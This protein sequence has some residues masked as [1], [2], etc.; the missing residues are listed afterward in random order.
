MNIK[1]TDQKLRNLR[2]FM[3]LVFLLTINVSFAQTLIIGSGTTRTVNGSAAGTDSGPMLRVSNTSTL[4]FSKYHYLYTQAELS[5]IPAGATITGI[6]WHKA[7]DAV[8]NS[9]ADFAIWLRN[10]SRTSILP[11]T[12][13][14]SDLIFNATKVYEDTTRLTTDTGWVNFNITPF[15]Y[16]GYALEISTDFGQPTGVSPFSSAGLAWSRDNINDR[17]ISQNAT[18]LGTSLTLARTVRPMIRFTYTV[19]QACVGTPN[20]GQTVSSDTFACTNNAI[21]LDLRGNTLAPGVTFEWEYSTNNT[22]YTS[23]GNP[24]ALPRKNVT[25][26]ADTWVRC[27]VVCNGG[28]AVYSNPLLIKVFNA[29]NGTYTVNAA[30]PTGGTNFK[31][32]KDLVNVLSCAGLA[33]STI[34]NIIPNSGPYYDKLELSNISGLSSVNTLRILGNNNEIIVNTQAVNG[35]REIALLSNVNNVTLKDIK[36]KSSST[37]A[38]GMLI[39]NGCSADS[40]VNCTIDLSNIVTTSSLSNAGIIFSGTNA[41]VSA[42]GSSGVGCVVMGNTII[43]SPNAGGVYYGIGLSADADSNIIYNNTIQNAYYAGIYVNINEHNKI[44]NNTIT[45]SNKMDGY[46]TYYG[47]YTVSGNT[48]GNVIDGNK[49]LM[50]VGNG[51]SNTSA[52][53]GIYALGDGTVQNPVI[54][55]NNLIMGFDAGASYGLYASGTMHTK[56]YHNTIN[57]DKVTNKNYISYGIYLTGTN[58]GLDIKNNIVNITG[59]GL[60][61]KFGVYFSATSTTVGD[62]QKNNIYLNSSVT[63]GNQYYGYYNTTNCS[64]I[65]DFQNLATTLEVGSPSTDPLYADP[66]NGDYTPTASALI[67][68]GDNVSAFVAKD[69]NG[70]DRASVP[71]IGAFESEPSNSIDIGV[72]EI[73]L[74]SNII[75]ADSHLI[76]VK[77]QNFSSVDITSFKVTGTFN[78]IAL[79][80]ISYNDTINSLLTNPAQ[81]SKVVPF[82]VL[83]LTNGVHE[84]KVW[85]LLPNGQVDT[86]YNNDTLLANIRTSLSGVYT[87]NSNQPTQGTN[88]Q[89]L[90]DLSLALNNM[91][92][93]GPVI[94]NMVA[95]SGPY[96]GKFALESIPGTSAVNTITINGNNNEVNTITT[97]TNGTRE[98]L[99]LN[100]VKYTTIKD[101]IFVTNAT[102]GGY[103]ALITGGSEFDSII[104]C[105]FD[106]SSV[107]N[108]TS[109]NSVGI[110]LSGTNASPI[111]TGISASKIVLKGNTIIGSNTSVGAYYGITLTAGA[112]SNVIIDNNIN[113]VYYYGIYIGVSNDNMIARNTLSR[114]T[115]TAGFTTYYGIYSVTGASSGHIIDANVIKDFADAAAS[116]TSSNYGIYMAADAIAQKPIIISNNILYNFNSG[117]VTA[118]GI[119]T[120]ANVYFYNNT[121]D[122]SFLTNRAGTMYGLYAT[123]TNSGCEFK[124]NIVSYTG[125]ST[126]IKYGFY[127]GTATA[128]PESQKNNIYINTTATG[129]SNYGY[130]VTAMATPAALQASA[131]ANL[132]VG[133]PTL[134]PQFVN[135]ANGD[136]TPS[137]NALKNIGDN[138][139][140]FVPKDFNYNFRSIAPTIGAIELYGNIRNDIGIAS[141]ESP[142]TTMC[143]DTQNLVV[144]VANYGANN[145]Y[146]FKVTGTFNGT[147]L[148]TFTFTDTL[149]ATQ[150]NPTQTSVDVALGNILIV[151]G[152]NNLVLW[153]FAP[154]NQVDTINTNDTIARTIIPSMSGNYTV[155]SAVATG[156][157]NFQTLSD[158]SSALTDVGLCGP[159]VINVL[160]NSGPY[161]QKLSLS[162]IP[163]LSNVNTLTINGNNNEVIV[164]TAATNGSREMLLLQNV[165]NVTVR[166]L[167]FSTSGTAAWGALITGGSHHDSIINCTF[168]LSNIVATAA[169]SNAG[170]LFSGTNATANA[171]GASGTN[172][173]LVN[174]TLIG[175]SAAGGLYY[176]ITLNADADSNVIY[177]NN[178]KNAYTY[179]IYIGVS[180]FNQIRNNTI[181]RGE[182]T[183]GFASSYYGINLVTGNSYGHIIEGNIINDSVAV[184]T[185]TNTLYGIYVG[186]DATASDPIVIS[187]NLF[188]NSNQG[189]TYGMYLTTATNILTYHNTFDFNILT[190]KSYATYGIYSTGTNT[191]CEFKNNIISITG[192]GNG[193]IYGAYYGSTTALSDAQMNNIYI[194]TPATGSKYY[195]Y[196]GSAYA[197]Q[198]LFKTAHP[199][200][201]IGSPEVNPMF[202]NTNVGNYM[203]TSNALIAVGLNL[204]S[205]VPQDIVGNNR[206]SNPTIGAFEYD[207]TLQNNIGLNH[208]VKPSDNYCVD[209]Q[210]VSIEVQ[211]YGSNNINSFKI[212]GQYNGNALDT[213]V[214]NIPLTSILANLDSSKTTI[215]LT[216]LYVDT[217]S[218]DLKLWVVN[219]N[220]QIDIFNANDTV[221]ATLKA[222]YFNLNTGSDTI[223]TGEVFN[224]NIAP[225]VDSINIVWQQ[226][227]DNAIWTNMNGING[228]SINITQSQNTYYRAFVNKGLNGC[229]TNSRRIISATPQILEWND[230][231]VCSNDDA[232]LVAK[233]APGTV[234]KWYENPEDETPIFIGDTM[235]INRIM[236]DKTYF[237]ESAVGSGEG[238]VGPTNPSVVGTAG[239]ATMLNATFFTVHQT[240]LLKSVDVF[241]SSLNLNGS[242][243]ITNE[244][245][246][247]VVG[248]YNFRTAVTG[249]ST[250]NTVNINQVLTPGNYSMKQGGSGITLYRNSTGGNYPYSSG[251]ITLTSSDYT[252]A[253]YYVHF[254]N[255]KFKTG[256]ATPRQQITAIAL[257]TPYV[258]LGDDIEACMD[259][260]DYIFLNARNSGSDIVWNNG[261]RDQVIGVKDSG[262]YFVTVTNQSQC[263]ASDTINI[264]KKINPTSLLIDDTIVCEGARVT[265]DAG[266]YG[267]EYYW[268]NGVTSYNNSVERSGIYKVN[269]V[270]TNGCIIQDSVEVKMTGAFPKYDRVRVRNIS[271]NKF[272]FLIEN[273]SGATSYKWKFGDGATAYTPNATHAYSKGGNYTVV[274]ELASDCGIV[275]DTLTV[276]I[277]NN[278]GIDKNT[279]SAGNIDIYPNPTS[280]TLNIAVHSDNEYIEYYEVLDMAGR[281]I[282]RSSSNLPKVKILQID[283]MNL[284]NGMY[285]IKTVTNQTTYFSKFNKIN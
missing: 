203:P 1:L 5:N 216:H 212:T 4:K 152:T 175:S 37:E 158:L 25:L 109:T 148:D 156:G 197:S 184:T 232:I 59:G 143:A 120:A 124:N 100:D 186:A 147:P 72:A 127:Y 191:G 260:T 28:T 79:D 64:T 228:S 181:S 77:V 80:T 38:W 76:S 36:F 51:A 239:T 220:N 159:V 18:T 231:A 83:N 226:S 101:L 61:N 247:Q 195:A 179:G 95:N 131:Y 54:I 162:N 190:N 41:V 7:N 224:L 107:T 66:L 62:M 70:V 149:F 128:I 217:N 265:L 277:L 243:V 69:I 24:S 43:G 82:K 67:A 144:K 284:T 73:V 223:C 199:A 215:N 185:S 40:I 134:D 22:T 49:I 163:E 269:I 90:Q 12:Q 183:T 145:V 274:V 198:A 248:T 264:L 122:F 60:G 105:T 135:I 125:G 137:N 68:N 53:Y 218:N 52:N 113:N 222:A 211:N 255:W 238:K 65:T 174:N 118:L 205:I 17:T 3:I 151:P 29:L 266:P 30:Q 132:E 45:R 208:L 254:Y 96:A 225:S 249:T 92:V 202:A 121:V 229:N 141:I 21:D 56:F 123:G 258:D 168:N 11:V 114:S 20:A 170:I 57:I 50:D 111:G 177:N 271:Q 250:P 201:E 164:P 31:S 88:F 133:S 279:L 272:E 200:Y 130:V 16:N 256:C 99:L 146:G 102:A 273:P 26:T 13:L 276:H 126:G 81:I 136:F 253:T 166:D 58:T 10:S 173:A 268:S 227:F 176:G 204:N 116:N 262:K 154:N 78:G 230:T 39:T 35:R 155:N 55:S 47:I 240:T 257:P 261:R 169:A 112:D 234:I 75:C 129:T 71:T 236:N 237:I 213:F 219:V 93:C 241:A 194:N 167:L 117:T 139:T 180:K 221:N 94:I 46:G 283:V 86:I 210:M 103:G 209:S 15:V 142:G 235:R 44:V 161:N 138:V 104:N 281:L 19:P 42:A 172:I 245:N 119:S 160:P 263:T 187:N 214:F 89:S 275:T 278:T 192:G 98:M 233:G 87:V 193:T 84:L 34:I 63:T 27:K 207:L 150:V 14:F 251:S 2:L 252:T 108:T 6:A 8:L 91:G 280:N 74:P 246:G 165:S 171:A 23:W 32:I 242:V 178:I 9:P 189:T 85:T 196:L 153:T 157:T 97:A 259:S 106:L 206:I 182:K 244:D 140:A 48:P 115:K 267:K 33:G 110:A 188:Y 285:Q 282:T 270:G